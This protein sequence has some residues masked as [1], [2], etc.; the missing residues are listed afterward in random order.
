M[1]TLW[2]AAKATIAREK[3]MK[4]WKRTWKI[5]LIESVNPHWDDLWKKF[6]LIE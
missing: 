4:R 6:G 5:Q 3:A 2:P 1:F